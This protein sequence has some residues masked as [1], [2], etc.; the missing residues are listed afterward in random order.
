[1]PLYEYEC[2]NCNTIIEK[3]RS[4]LMRNK[5]LICS[6]CHNIM[7]RKT[8]YGSQA[9]GFKGPGFYTND[10]KKDKEK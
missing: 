10:Y 9:I 1:M 5:E 2:E 8:H 4:V 3:S 6:N 7:K